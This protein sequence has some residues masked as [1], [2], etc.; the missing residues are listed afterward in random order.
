[1]LLLFTFCS[2]YCHYISIIVVIKVFYYCWNDLSLLIVIILL[3]LFLLVFLFFVVSFVN[4]SFMILFIF[5]FLYVRVQIFQRV[6]M[7]ICVY[8]R[9][10]SCAS[11][12]MYICVSVCLYLCP[13]GSISNAIYTRNSRTS[14]SPQTVSCHLLDQM[15][16]STSLPLLSPADLKRPEVTGVAYTWVD[17]FVV[18]S[19]FSGLVFS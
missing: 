3:F 15:Y 18:L 10:R 11:V 1:M 9:V 17:L 6:C 19:F 8:A 5:C 2:Y 12:C 7:C 4:L 16:V 13:H 14:T